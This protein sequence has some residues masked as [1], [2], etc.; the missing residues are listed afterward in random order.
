MPFSWPSP[1]RLFRLVAEVAAPGDP[2]TD[3]TT[4]WPDNRPRVELGMLTLSSAA[5]DSLE[6]EKKL[7]F[8]PGQVTDRI[9]PS[10][11]PLLPTRDG[12]YAISSRAA[13]NCADGM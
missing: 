6:A 2:I 7:L 10:A 11:D 4:P 1:E 9:E 12:A 8:L 5:A 13:P 3:A